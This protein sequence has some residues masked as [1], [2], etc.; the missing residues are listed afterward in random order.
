MIVRPQ[1]TRH[2][3]I[4]RTCPTQTLMEATKGDA[5]LLNEVAGDEGSNYSEAAS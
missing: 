4:G 3:A 1:S 5:I 2:N